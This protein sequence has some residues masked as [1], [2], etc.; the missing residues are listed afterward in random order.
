MDSVGSCEGESHVRHA[1]GC[2]G[3]VDGGRGLEEGRRV[4]K[5]SGHSEGHFTRF[6][7]TASRLRT[8]S[9]ICGLL[10]VEMALVD[11]SQPR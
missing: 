7:T 2:E 4:A 11:K 5:E 9:S 1:P 10:K 6:R 3:L 8:L